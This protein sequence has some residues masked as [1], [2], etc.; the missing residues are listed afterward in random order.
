MLRESVAVVDHAP[1]VLSG[2]EDA[3]TL[4][5]RRVWRARPTWA[6]LAEG[7]RPP[8]LELDELALGEWAHE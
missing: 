3:G 6:A 1:G 5:D 8:T 2:A 4:C 7:Q